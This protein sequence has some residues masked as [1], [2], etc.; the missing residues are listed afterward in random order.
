MAASNRS[1]VIRKGATSG[2]L[3]PGDPIHDQVLIEYDGRSAEVDKGLA[4][5]ILELWQRGFRTIGS[6]EQEVGTAHAWISFRTLREAKRLQRLIGERATLIVPSA[7]N[8]A[9]ATAA[10]WEAG[11]T[12]RGM[13]GVAFHRSHIPSVLKT[14]NGLKRRVKKGST[15]IR[16][17]AI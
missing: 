11:Y 7:E 2:P 5:L 15:S 1:K 10:S 17:Q 9:D 14:V 3:R 4:A 13:A 12:V 6:C 8:Y 16:R